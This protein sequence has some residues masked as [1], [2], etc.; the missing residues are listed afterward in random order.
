MLIFTKKG[1][2]IAAV[3]I[4]FVT[5]LLTHVLGCNREVATYLAHTR[6]LLWRHCGQVAG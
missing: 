3:I 1:K 4:P 6:C 5:L 2:N